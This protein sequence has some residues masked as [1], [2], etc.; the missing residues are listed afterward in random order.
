MCPEA[1]ERQNVGAYH[2]LGLNH[3]RVL[4]RC[5]RGD[6]PIYG[7]EYIVPGWVFKPNVAVWTRS[8]CRNV[9]GNKGAVPQSGTWLLEVVGAQNQIAKPTVD[10]GCQ[11][12]VY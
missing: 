3:H 5:N 8:A 4:F 12:I 7:L 9:E 1:E 10:H 2:G 11:L 6:K